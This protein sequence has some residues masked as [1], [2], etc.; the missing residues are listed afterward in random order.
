MNVQRFVL[1]FAGSMVLLTLL[2][3]LTVSHWF[4]LGTAF[5][6]ANLLQ[7]SFSGFCP[8]AS[9]LR[10]AGLKDG[11]ALQRAISR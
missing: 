6:G 9:L 2:L 11:P 4:L 10:A 5:V 8:L 1:A 7:A 3:A